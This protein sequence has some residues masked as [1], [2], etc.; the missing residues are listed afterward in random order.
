M[1]Q[2]REQ[3]VEGS[4]SCPP[5]FSPPFLH[6]LYFPPSLSLTPPSTLAKERKLYRTKSCRWGR[7]GRK[8]LTFGVV[9]DV[10]WPS[11]HKYYFPHHFFPHTFPFF[12]PRRLQCTYVY[13]LMRETL[14]AVATAV[15]AGFF[16]FNF[17]AG[18]FFSFP[19]LLPPPHNTKEWGAND[20][21]LPPPLDNNI[22]T[23]IS[24]NACFLS[25][26]Y[27]DTWEG[28]QVCSV[29]IFGSQVLFPTW[30]TC[31]SAPLTP[32]YL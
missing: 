27:Y 7:D 11:P 22:T 12:S 30:F 18:I 21:K 24:K 23:H 16:F 10:T 28:L 13:L 8:P 1:W 6:S 4:I 20:V 25:S 15:C 31:P 29:I 9:P 2:P 14:L 5:P 3:H 32:R 17:S 19:F 26:S